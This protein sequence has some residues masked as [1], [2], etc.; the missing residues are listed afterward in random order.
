MPTIVQGVPTSDWRIYKAKFDMGSLGITS[1]VTNPLTPAWNP[2]LT[3]GFFKVGEGGFIGSGLSKIN[4]TPDPN[5]RRFTAPLIQELD[6]VVDT[7]RSSN[8][9]YATDERF[10]FQKNLTVGN[11]TFI[12]P[13]TIEIACT[14]NTGECN[15]DGFGNSPELW[16][17]GIFVEH[18]E[19]VGQSLMCI[20]GTFPVITKLAGQTAQIKVRVTY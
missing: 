5:L 3:R 4:R 13:T 18:P 9:R 8:I 20:Y 7:T 2:L 14:L 15:N 17:I 10:T 6:A 1:G 16:E 19:I 11:F 12:A